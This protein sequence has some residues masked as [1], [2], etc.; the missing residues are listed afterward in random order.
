MQ[1][2]T[3]VIASAVASATLTG[4]VSL[5]GQAVQAG[6]TRQQIVDDSAEQQRRH[7]ENQ[8]KFD[9]I[10]QK[11]SAGEQGVFVTR[12]EHELTIQRTEDSIKRVEARLESIETDIDVL[13][14][15]GRTGRTSRGAR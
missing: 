8:K 4:V 1:D 15:R 13:V 7:E 9:A 11:L 12:R 3:M 6:K 14:R 2:Y 10:E 5:I